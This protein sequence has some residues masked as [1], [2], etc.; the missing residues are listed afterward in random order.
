M[1]RILVVD[2][3][4]DP[5][6]LLREIFAAEGWHVDTA[7]SPSQAFSVAKKE[8]IDP[9]VS[10]VNLE[11]NQSGLD[12]LKDLRT[13]CPVILVTGFRTLDSA[14]E[15]AREGAWDFISKPFKV[16]EA[17]RLRAVRSITIETAAVRTARRN[18][19]PHVTNKAGYWGA[20]R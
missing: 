16:Q 10:D 6:E 7:L 12:L 4:Q 13:Q 14:V 11:A 18:N 1:K 5:C 19:F 8:T 17:C 2:D 20:L 15:A 3:D 9:V